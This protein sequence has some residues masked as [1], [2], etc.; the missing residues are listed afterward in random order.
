MDDYYVISSKVVEK[1]LEDP[2]SHESCPNFAVVFLSWDF[3]PTPLEPL[4]ALL[5]R[6]A[7]SGLFNKCKLI[8]EQRNAS[9]LVHKLI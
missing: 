6:L 2:V 7:T 1:Y 3:E 4:N 8:T 5:N 9:L